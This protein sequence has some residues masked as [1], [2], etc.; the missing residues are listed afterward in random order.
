MAYLLDTHTF[1]WFVEGN[2]ELP[3]KVVSKI[4]NINEP[5]FISIASFWEIAIK[6]QLGKL[7]IDIPFDELFK[8]ITRNQIQ[9]IE[10]GEEHLIELLALE[11]HH[12]DPF[13]R[14]IIAQAK[15]ENLILLSKDKQME[16]YKIKVE[17]EA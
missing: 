15:S 2:K 16:K 14:L 5:C 1:L 7:I 3:K 11:A 9:I 8:F 4:T 17:C 13:D 10:I 6:L 12:R